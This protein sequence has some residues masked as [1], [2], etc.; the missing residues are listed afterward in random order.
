[1]AQIARITRTTID[2]ERREKDRDRKRVERANA[3]ELG[4]VKP[5]HADYAIVEGLAF[6]SLVA[7]NKLFVHEAR[8][9][10]IN[11]MLIVRVA[12]DILTE[13]F[14]YDRTLAKAAVH[15][16]LRPRARHKEFGLIPSTRPGIGQPTYVTATP[17][18]LGRVG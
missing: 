18:C 5:S 17:V 3:K 12:T 6:A 1:M 9:L 11:L 13:R 4:L 8:Y 14:H 7:D 15:A 16:K 2:A 10:P